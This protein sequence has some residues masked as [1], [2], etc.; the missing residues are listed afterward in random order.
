VLSWAPDLE[1]GA[2]RKALAC[3]SLPVAFHHVAVMADGHQGYGVP[4]GAVLALDGAISPYAV[5]NDIGCGMAIAPTRLTRDA[6]LPVRDDIMRATQRAIP[7]GTA[8][9]R[10]PVVDAAVDALLHRA[11]DA[12][13][14]ASA[15]SGLPLSTSQSADAGRGRPLTRDDFV[16]RGRTQVGTLG[17]GNHFVELL[18]GPDDDV[19]LM[20]HSGSRGVGGL[21]CNNFHRMALRWC[22]REGHALAD[23]G[24]AWLPIGDDAAGHVATGPWHRVGA[25][26]ERAMRS[27]LDYA[28]QNRHRMLVAVAAHVERHFPGA[29]DWDGAVNIHHNDATHERHFGRD[30]WVHRKGAVKA[31]RG[32]PTVTPGS[33]GTGTY[34]GRGLGNADAY[35]SCS[36]GAGRVRSRGMARREL[37]LDRE[38]ATITAAGGKVFATSTAAV[39]DEMPGAYKD[40][41]EVMANQADL[42]EV[43]RR[44]TPLATYKGADPPRRRRDRARAWRPEA[45]R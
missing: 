5:G 28:E 12:M 16:R 45:E 6:L 44:F 34:L 3:A 7:S 32:T 17:A 26:Y 9:H 13:E 8:S 21:V 35:E 31:S 36:H 33:M 30:V 2:R 25:A 27:A 19:W 29:L 42:V 38:L 18:V 24:L 11:F 20:L 40:L 43:V 4:I 1:E 41:D 23:P 37:R 14:E 10:E 39:L 15:A 22:E